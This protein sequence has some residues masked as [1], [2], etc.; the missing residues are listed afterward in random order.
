[1]L[2]DGEWRGGFVERAGVAMNAADDGAIYLMQTRSD[3]S[4]DEVRVDGADRAA[5]AA[6]ALHGTETAFR[7]DD[8]DDEVIAAVLLGHYRSGVPF[9]SLP[10][11][12]Q[13]ALE[14]VLQRRG[15]LARRIAT[16]LP[17]RDGAAAPSG[18]APAA[19]SG[20]APAAASG[21]VPAT[22][23]GDATAASPGSDSGRGPA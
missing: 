5:L 22:A 16:L 21:D 9:R 12:L 23:S 17:P 6:L 18:D 8:H 2:T 14:G 19:A 13:L 11:S 20:A 7:W 1:M 4:V 10:E 3:G 15:A